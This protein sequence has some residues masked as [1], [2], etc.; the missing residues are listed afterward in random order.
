M[1][2]QKRSIFLVLREDNNGC[3]CLKLCEDENAIWKVCRTSYVLGKEL[4]KIHMQRRGKMGSGARPE[5]IPGGHWD[6]TR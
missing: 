4:W 3:V 5:G 6:V 1:R 2:R